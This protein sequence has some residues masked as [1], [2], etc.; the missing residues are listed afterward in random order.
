[1]RHVLI[2]SSADIISTHCHFP[3]HMFG[4][5][6]VRDDAQSICIPDL[7]VIHQFN[8][9]IDKLY[10]RIGSHSTDQQHVSLSFSEKMNWNFKYLR[11]VRK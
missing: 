5:F 9:K 2:V 3:S 11:S 10:H 4:R 1:M 6:A 7:I 8:A